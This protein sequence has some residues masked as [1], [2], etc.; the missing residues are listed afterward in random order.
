M[1]NNVT[2][3][4]AVGD[5]RETSLPILGHTALLLMNI[6]IFMGLFSLGPTLPFVRAAFSKT[7]HVDLAVQLVGSAAGFAF[8]VTALLINR[9]FVYVEYRRI[10]VFA[11]AAFGIFGAGG[12]LVQNLPIIILSRIGVGAAAACIVTASLVAVGDMSS[13]RARAKL[14][15]MQQ[16]I[17]CTAAIGLYPLMG[18]ASQY[19]WRLPFFFHLSAVLVIPLVLT[20]PSSRATPHST[21]GLPPA[22]ISKL[23]PFF[24]VTIVLVGMV[25]FIS[26][27]FGSLYLSRLGETKALM[28]A[29]PSTAT[30]IGA[31]GGAGSF[32]WLHS[33]LG[34]ERTFAICLGTMAVGLVVVGFSTSAVSVA[35]GT[36]FI[37][38]G[39]GAFPANLNAAAIRAAPLNPS[40]TLGIV[41]GLLYGSMILF[42]LVAAPFSQQAR[43][44]SYLILGLSALS[45][46]AAAGFLA[47]SRRL[48]RPDG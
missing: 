5:E 20:L 28:L 34:I 33:R 6:F 13:A 23:G 29:L 39:T 35:A 30:S 17:G 1:S 27:I 18:L 44:T 36:L 47:Q 31:I 8:A 12:A 11:L 21:S 7:A 46:V 22:S 40:R 14:L 24:L 3:A 15:G 10:F 41:N 48:G 38:L 37:G 26:S 25:V 32:I 19:D 45:A 2:A 4:V 43:T 42:P 9:L 16:V